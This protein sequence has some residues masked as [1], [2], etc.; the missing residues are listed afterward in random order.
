MLRQWDVVLYLI[1]FEGDLERMCVCARV[2]AHT[3]S[4]THALYV[5][6][7]DVSPKHLQRLKESRLTK[8]LHTCKPYMCTV[9]KYVCIYTCWRQDVFWTNFL[10]SLHI[11]HLRLH[12]GKKRKTMWTQYQHLKSRW[13]WTKRPYTNCDTLLLEVLKASNIKVK[14]GGIESKWNQV[15]RL[16]ATIQL[17]DDLSF[18]TR[19]HLCNLHVHFFY[20]RFLFISLISWIS[21]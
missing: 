5:G 2:Y 14:G 20:R 18:G 17:E 21:L 9:T 7:S 4:V 15:S 6:H 19:T 3:H 12:P 8:A 10:F 1:Y 16:E 13:I 11:C